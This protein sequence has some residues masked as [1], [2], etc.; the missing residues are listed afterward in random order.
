[1]DGAA[2]I[3]RIGRS[4]NRFVTVSSLVTAVVLEIIG[5]RTLMAGVAEARS[6]QPP[7]A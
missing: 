6:P 5:D 2:A 3:E 7:R 1:M 4:Q